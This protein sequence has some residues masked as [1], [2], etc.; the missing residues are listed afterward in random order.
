MYIMSK[1]V[2]RLIFTDAHKKESEFITEAN[3]PSVALHNIV[4]YYK[5]NLN[6][7]TDVTIDELLVTPKQSFRDYDYRFEQDGAFSDRKYLSSYNKNRIESNYGSV[8]INIDGTL[9]KVKRADLIK[10]LNT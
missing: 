3:T 7:F 6:D 1:Y 9:H 2:Y 10:L 4:E 5:L 8:E